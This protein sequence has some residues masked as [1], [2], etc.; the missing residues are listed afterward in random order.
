MENN[1]I[2][3]REDQ[4]P[5]KWYNVAADIKEHLAP[6][7]NPGT[8][9]PLDPE[10]LKPLF[11][12][13]LIEQEVS[14]EK[15]IDIPEEV[16]D[17]LAIW[18]PTPLVRARK[19]EEYLDTPAQI[20]YKNEG[21]SPPGSH[22]PNTA[23]AQVYYNKKEG[24]KRLTTETGAGQWG[25]ALS[26]ACQRF[27]L[28]CMVY[29]VKCSFEQKPF[30]K[31]LI[32]LWD[33]N[34]IPS[35]STLT[36]SGRAILA[37]YPDTSGSLGIAIS[38][39]V[40]DAAKRSDSHY[41]LGSVLNHVLLHQS[42]IGLEIKQQ[43]KEA[44][45][46]PD[47]IIGCCGGGSNFGGTVFPF[48]PDQLSGEK[49]KFLA[50]EPTSCPT[51]TKGEYAYDFGDTAKLTPLLKM[52]TLGHDFIPPAIHAGGLRYHGMSPL[53]SA[54]IK[55]GV[56]E[57]VNVHQTKIFEAAKI[58]TSTEGLVPAPETSHAIRVAIDQALEAKKSGEPKVIIFTFSGHGHFDMAAYESYMDEKL[59]DYEY[60]EDAIKESMKNLPTV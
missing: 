45:V 40:E 44:G 27:G 18:R 9:K 28:E 25:S 29:M 19:L 26:Y 20:Y 54:L 58:F 39:A 50:V 17:Q 51:M 3:L 16:L 15:W 4:L 53:V 35:P 5:R 42:I 23:V 12:S 2:I 14:V 6:P 52:Y 38:E 10:E 59:T 60:P 32:R 48:V 31:T 41:S 1:R 49:I 13:A 11:P 8:K 55:M 47:V 24:I 37:K 34:V 7:L 36:E 57:S 21:V 33:G 56:I 30:R 43:I 46:K 22:K